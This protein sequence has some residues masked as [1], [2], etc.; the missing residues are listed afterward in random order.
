MKEAYGYTIEGI[1]KPISE[2]DIK[3]IDVIEYYNIKN[4][5]VYNNYKVREKIIKRIINYQDF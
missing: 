4:E 2:L 3:I 5:P 1:S